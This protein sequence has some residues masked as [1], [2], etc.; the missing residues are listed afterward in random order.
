[1][2]KL[3]LIIA[4]T[5]ITLQL[6]AGVKPT[7]IYNGTAE[8]SIHWS[9]KFSQI[10]NSIPEI[11]INGKWVSAN[12]FNSITWLKKEGSNDLVKPIQYDGR[13]ELL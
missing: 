12:E 2:K 13:V 8:F 11:K 3:N 4:F 10:N 5:I 1:M 7:I 6:F 9:E